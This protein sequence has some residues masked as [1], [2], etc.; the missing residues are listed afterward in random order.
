MNMKTLS[1]VMMFQYGCQYQK[2]ICLEIPS[3]NEYIFDFLKPILKG[4]LSIEIRGESST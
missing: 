2:A 4:L 1:S 3:I